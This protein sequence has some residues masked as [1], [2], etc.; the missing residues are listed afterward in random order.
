MNE[1]EPRGDGRRR[2]YARG[3]GG[4]VGERRE[5]R[6]V[7]VTVNDGEDA[8]TESREN[9]EKEKNEKRNVFEGTRT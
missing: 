5:R 1:R 3:G 7:G 8:E 6:V 9:E 2:V 4:V